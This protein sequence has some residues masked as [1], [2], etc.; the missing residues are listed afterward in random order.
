MSLQALQS[1][2]QTLEKNISYS[3]AASLLAQVTGLWELAIQLPSMPPSGAISNV[4]LIAIREFFEAALRAYIKCKDI[5]GIEQC[6]EVLKNIYQDHREHLG[7]TG[8]QWKIWG[9][10]LTFLLSYNKIEDFHSELEAV[11]WDLYTSNKFIHFAV[12]LEQF[13]MEGNYQEV[14][15]A[16]KH[17]PSEEFE[18]FVDRISDTIRFEIAASFEKAYTK[19]TLQG[20]CE[21]LQLTSVGELENFTREYRESTGKN[22]LR[23]E[24]NFLMIKSE[25]YKMH[26]IPKWELI[27]QAV[28]YA[29]EL[30]RIV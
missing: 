19:M 22:I 28:N 11:P 8:D 13:F 23:I 29:I 25:E 14:L 5:T 16:K 20:A 30:E 9:L 26:E 21:L 10:Y 27:N 6:F 4:E 1:G 7:N 18:F 24:G 12:T 15:Q 2:T 17:S 3:D